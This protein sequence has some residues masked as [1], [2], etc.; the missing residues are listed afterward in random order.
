[1]TLD[2]AIVGLNVVHA[3]GIEDVAARGMLRMFASRAVALFASHVPLR[4]L[5]GVNVV[6]HGMASIASWACGPL[7]IVRRIQRRPPIGAIGHKIGTP[8]VMGDVPLR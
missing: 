1:M 5:F 4:N 7:H 8:E 6:S 2:A 3:R